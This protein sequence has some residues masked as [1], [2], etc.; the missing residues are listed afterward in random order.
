MKLVLHQCAPV[1]LRAGAML[2][3][4]ALYLFFGV[5]V[6]LVTT[7]PRAATCQEALWCHAVTPVFFGYSCSNHTSAT[8][9]AAVAA[10]LA[11]AI[12]ATESTALS[13]ITSSDSSSTA[14]G[15]ATAITTASSGIESWKLTAED[16]LEVR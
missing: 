5:T 8:T 11:P 14:A 7:R 12:V 1:V 4:N 15:T 3:S 2:N 10:P 16:R 13:V 6:C 9:A